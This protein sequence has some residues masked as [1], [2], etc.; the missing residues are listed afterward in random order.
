MTK[1][2]TIVIELPTDQVR[3]LADVIDMWADQR[4]TH[5]GRPTTAT[6]DH[7]PYAWIAEFRETAHSLAE[8]LREGGKD[9]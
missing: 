6:A 8:Q 4:T 7:Y 1:T 5:S 9:A 2:A 3:A